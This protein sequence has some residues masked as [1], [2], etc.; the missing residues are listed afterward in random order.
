MNNKVGYKHYRMD[1]QEVFY[2]GIGDRE[3]PYSEDSRNPHWHHIV[4][5]VGYSIEIIKENITWEQACEWEK[6]EIKQLGRRDLGLGSLVNLTDGG[7]GSQGVI[8][9]EERKQNVSVG[10]KKAMQNPEVI[11][12]MKDAKK[13][14]VPWNNGLKGIMMGEE[15]PNFGNK[16]TQEQKNVAGKKLQQV[17]QDKGGFSDEH[18]LKLKESRKG[19]TPAAKFGK[20][21]VIWIRKNFDRNQGHTYQQ[22]ANKFNVT[23]GCIRNIIIGKSWQNL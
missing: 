11:Q 16:W 1:T 21:D 4:N 23:L 2:V 22:F 12:K 5:K 18:L 14:F 7:E 3:R 17:W 8:V 20:E 19:R 10:T 6:S 9:T 13:D 15:N